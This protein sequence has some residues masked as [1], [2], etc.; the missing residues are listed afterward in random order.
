MLSGLIFRPVAS[1]AR[2]ARSSKFFFAGWA[3]SSY[4]RLASSGSP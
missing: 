2:L 1:E 3:K 4:A